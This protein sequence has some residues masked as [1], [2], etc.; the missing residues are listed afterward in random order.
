M[1]LSTPSSCSSSPNPQSSPTILYFIFLILF[2]G[3]PPL[4]GSTTNLFFSLSSLSLVLAPSQFLSMFSRAR[5]VSSSSSFTVFSLDSTSSSS[6]TSLGMWQRLYSAREFKMFPA[7]PLLLILTA[8]LICLL[9]AVLWELTTLNRNLG[10][11]PTCTRAWCFTMWLFLSC[12]TASPQCSFAR[13]WM[14][15]L[16]SPTYRLGAP[17]L[18][19]SSSPLLVAPG[20]HSRQMLS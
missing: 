15:L 12:F 4:S 10:G 2:R 1:L 17:F 20:L 13:S 14:L 16:L 8:S 3:L 18:G 11:S 5:R 6:T 19:L 9:R 7:P